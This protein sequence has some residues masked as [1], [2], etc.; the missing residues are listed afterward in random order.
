MTTKPKKQAKK[1]AEV[2]LS[3]R[4]L[5]IEGQS[6]DE[7]HEIVKGVDFDLH[8]GEVLGLIGE[9]GAGK[10]TIGLAAMG[11]ARPGCK[12]T[13]GDIMFDGVNLFNATENDKR[14]LRGT[15]YVMVATGN[16]D[17]SGSGAS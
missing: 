6:D 15:H 8:R 11:F 4:N 9:S 7:W 10:S 5:H 13:E 12:I 1:D 16:N 17:A 14:A 3:I 2:L